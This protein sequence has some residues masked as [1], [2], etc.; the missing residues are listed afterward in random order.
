L[1][2]GENRYERRQA[3][4][5]FSPNRQPRGRNLLRIPF[6]W[7]SFRWPEPVPDHKSAAM[8]NPQAVSG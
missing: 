2:A 7:N 8:V 4:E 1:H 5:W 3:A 6:L